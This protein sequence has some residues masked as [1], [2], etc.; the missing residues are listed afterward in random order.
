MSAAKRWSSADLHAVIE[1]VTPNVLGLL[2][3]SLPRTEAAIVTTLA[4][5]HPKQDVRGTVM[6]LAVLEQ[7]AMRG[8]RYTLPAAEAEQG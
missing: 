8:S 7:L 6:R 2:G 1:R 5:R 3:D 4:G